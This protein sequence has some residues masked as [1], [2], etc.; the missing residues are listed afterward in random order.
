MSA[1]PNSYVRFDW[2]KIKMAA[3]LNMNVQMTIWL[4]PVPADPKT[5]LLW[6]FW[7][8]AITSFVMFVSANYASNTYLLRRSLQS[9]YCAAPLLMIL[10]IKFTDQS[11]R[12]KE[13]GTAITWKHHGK[14]F[15]GLQILWI[16]AETL[17]I[18]KD[19]DKK[20]LEYQKYILCFKGLPILLN[21]VTNPCG[22][23]P[24]PIETSS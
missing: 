10:T 6:L 15:R 11:N 5:K 17:Q 7:V 2:S 9:S 21:F 16:I 12:R 4:L 1:L 18:G 3:N 8:T 14:R 20:E 19:D 13:F 24:K 23:I 22:Q